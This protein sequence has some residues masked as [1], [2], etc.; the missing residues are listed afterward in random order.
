[1]TAPIPMIRRHAVWFGVLGVALLAVGAYVASVWAPDLPVESLKAKYASAPSQFINVNGLQVHVRDEGPRDDPT[2]IVL[3]HGT[4]SS[5]HTW[6]GWVDSLKTTRRVVRFDLPGFGLTGPSKDNDYRMPAFVNAVIGVMDAL[7]VKRA[8]LGGNSL[9][10]GIAWHVA[11]AHPE[12]VER[13]VLVDAVGYPFT[14]ESVPIG[15]R[16]ARLPV[17]RVLMQR[18]LPRSV[19]EQSVRNVFGDPSKVTPELI[20]RYY[21]ITRREGNRAAVVARFKQEHADP[22]TTAIHTIRQPT[23]IVWGGNDHLIPPSNAVRFG[24]DI[25]GSKVVMFPELG[26]VPHEEDPAATYKALREFL[27]T[28]GMSNRP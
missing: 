2:P 12:R 20:Q 9:G 3:L 16:L 11:V 5:L 15:F 27:A 4:S 13:L 21:D 22:D 6:Q 14:S 18:M 26:H 28:S 8:V 25:P 19:V 10:G 1:M 7:G 17:L 23:L 24:R